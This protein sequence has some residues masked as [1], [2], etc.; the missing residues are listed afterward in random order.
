VDDKTPESFDRVFDT[1]VDSSFIL[2]RALRPELLRFLAFFASVAGP[3]GSRGQCDYAAAN[4][5]L[6]RLALRLNHRWP[7]RIVSINWGPWGTTGMAGAEVQKQFQKRGIQIIPPAAGRVLLNLEIRNG[8]KEDAHVVIGDGPWKVAAERAAGPSATVSPARVLPL[9]AGLV[10]S[11]AK[12][13]G[14]EILKTFDVSRDL[15]LQDHVLDGRPVVPAAVALE[16]MAEVAQTGW[17][18]LQ[19]IGLRDFAVLKGL[20]L[21]GDTKPVRIRARAVVEP[22]HDRLGVDVHVEIADA[23]PGGTLHYRATVEMGDRLPDA[24]HFDPAM[25]SDLGPFP[26]SLKDAYRDWLFHG[27]LFQGIETAHGFGETGMV[28]TCVPSSPALCLKDGPPGEWLIDPVVFDSALQMAVLWSRACLDMTPLPT[29]SKR[30]R[31]FGPLSPA[32]RCDM[33]VTS[34]PHPNSFVIDIAFIGPDGR[35]RGL[36]ESMECACSPTLNRLAGSHLRWRDTA[37]G[38]LLLASGPGSSAE[39]SLGDRP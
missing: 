4:E 27:P 39:R 20:V 8:R 21:D 18:D 29:R 5:V 11:H 13:E 23:S 9:A 37:G 3:F 14:F 22:P 6:N 1:K 25:R 38:R 15:Y 32:I 24:P 26:M 10:S 7:G 12:G 30:Y 2:S 36:L 34:R 33:R 35:L 17:P 16:L 19:V 31:R 28:A